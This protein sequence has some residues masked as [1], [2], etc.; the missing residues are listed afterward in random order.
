MAPETTAS[1]VTTESASQVAAIELAE[2]GP[3]DLIKKLSSVVPYVDSVTWAM[4]WGWAC[5][6]HGGSR[7]GCA[8]PPSPV[9][10]IQQKRKPQAKVPTPR[11]SETIRA[12]CIERDEY[13]AVTKKDGPVEV[14]HVYPVSMMTRPRT[15]QSTFWYMLR[16][17]WEP[18]MIEGWKRVVLGPEGTE[19]MAWFAL[20]PVE[21]SEDKK[22]L[23]FWLPVTKYLKSIAITTRPSLPS[24]LKHVGKQTKLFNCEKSAQICSG[25][26]ITMQT[27]DPETHPLPSLEILGTQWAL[28]CVLGMS[29]AADIASEELD[30]D[31]DEDPD[32]GEQL[33]ADMPAGTTIPGRRPGSPR[34]DNK[35]NIENQPPSRSSSKPAATVPLTPLSQRPATHKQDEPW[36]YGVCVF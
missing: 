26:M 33:V 30:S 23:N 6:T 3:S 20:Q 36:V 7:D 5:S 28:A 21:L 25:D 31:S 24:E 13:C 15:E 4:L 35:L 2:I 10:T 11:R 32:F 27:V 12:M 8:A 14:A 17:F 9:S 22:V 19:C 16:N 34:Q 1:D 29:G 18:E